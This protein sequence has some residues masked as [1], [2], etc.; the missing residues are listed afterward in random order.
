VKSK[1]T[2]NLV[3]LLVYLYIFDN[4]RYRNQNLSDMFLIKNGLKQ[5]DSFSLV[6]FSFALEYA[7]MRDQVNEEGL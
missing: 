4:A 3:H 7:I 5:G 6:L 1:E 2:Y